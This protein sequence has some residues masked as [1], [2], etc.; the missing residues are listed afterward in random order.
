[1][2]NLS[3]PKTRR[4]YPVLLLLLSRFS[5]V[6]RCATP[7]TAAHQA[8]P[9]L[10]FSR[11]EPWGGSSSTLYLKYFIKHR[12]V[13]NTLSY[14]GAGSGLPQHPT[15]QC[16]RTGCRVLVNWFFAMKVKVLVTHLCLTL[17]IPARLFCAWN[18]PGKNTGMGCQSLLQGIFLTQ[19]MNPCLLHCRQILYLVRSATREAI[20]GL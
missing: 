2:H 6:R 17:A 11:Q 10:G 8:P 14:L 12:M 4:T 9:S 19:G 5:R 15:S 3:C 16:Q 20:A 18:F 1:M 7:Q 13:A